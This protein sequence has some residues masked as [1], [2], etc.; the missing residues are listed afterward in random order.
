MNKP[1]L[2]SPLVQADRDGV[3]VLGASGLIG[4]ALLRQ[5][6]TAGV[7]I[8]AA[9]RSAQPAPELA[10]L[11]TWRL[12]PDFDLY[13]N[14]QAAAAGWPACA[15]V[16]S[17]GPLDALA[18]WLERDGAPALRRLVAI[19]STSVAT[20]QDSPEAGERVLARTL[21]HAEQRIIAH[22]RRHGIAWTIL[23]PTLVWGEGRD[24]NLTLIA[25]MARRRRW[26][27]VPGFATGCRQPIRNT[28]VARAMILAW[29]QPAANGHCLDLPGGQILTYLE[30]VRR[31]VAV[32]AP[33]CRVITLPASASRLALS[34][35]RRLRLLDGARAAI[36]ERM[37]QDLQFDG[38]PAQRLLG[39]VAA[40]F[41]P[42]AGDFPPT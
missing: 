2:A 27:A 16:L 33:D 23:R 15:T 26:L 24:R 22:C 13:A 40:G 9:S 10:G 36:I 4:A 1:P 19:G 32:A 11:A 37:A 38:G 25:A 6:H 35:A 8:H 41:Q 20:K 39:F 31:L 30:M 14:P 3:L 29:R 7:H 18:A 17:A 5:L 12:G 21:Q 42:V 34:A 28:E